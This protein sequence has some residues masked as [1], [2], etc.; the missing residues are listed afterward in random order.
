MPAAERK[1]AHLA[2]V[3]GVVLVH[4]DAV[5]VLAASISAAAG[6][7]AVLAHAAVAG[8][9]VAALLAVVLQL[10]ARRVGRQAS[11]HAA[12]NK[13]WSLSAAQ[14]CSQQTA[15]IPEP[16]AVKL[17]TRVAMS[18]RR[19]VSAKAPQKMRRSRLIQSA[20]QVAGPFV[21]VAS[22]EVDNTGGCTRCV[23]PP[24]QLRCC[25]VLSTASPCLGKL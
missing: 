1:T 14:L 13:V 24:Q 7:L 6:V 5:V 21:R 10:R 15:P 2:E 17:R 22:L 8:G 16:A 11:E 25:A 18:P 19:M 9:H 3:T 20:A 23:R 4:V 12:A